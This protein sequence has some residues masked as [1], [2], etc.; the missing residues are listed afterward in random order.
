MPCCPGQIS[1]Q[2]P[3]LQ[4][5]KS[6]PLEIPANIGDPSMCPQGLKADV[7]FRTHWSVASDWNPSEGAGK[8]C[9]DDIRM[10]HPAVQAKKQQL[11]LIQQCLTHPC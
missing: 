8:H 6:K 5:W 4:T 1:R 9:A 3:F 11:A 2:I 7:A 10:I